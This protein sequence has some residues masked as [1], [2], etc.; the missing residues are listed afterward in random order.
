MKILGIDPGTARVGWGVVEETGGKTSA[1]SF[2]CI[3]ATGSQEERL[4]KIYAQVTQ[5]IKT[6]SP[7]CLS[8]EKLFFST[9]VT[10]A[11][12]VGEARGVILLAAA[13]ASLPVLSYTPQEVKKAVAGV[14]NADKK[15]VTRMVALTLHLTKPPTPDD[16]ADALAIALTH[17][18]SYKMKAR[19]L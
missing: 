10:T 9:N 11:I 3:M 4:K 5:I 7:A 14:G 2:G 1:P 18:F 16:T 19:M 13:H 17:A 8:L 6:Y 12:S 15:Q